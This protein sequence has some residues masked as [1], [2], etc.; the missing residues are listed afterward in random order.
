[1]DEWRAQLHQRVA[2][3]YPET[4][5]EKPEAEREGA[6]PNSVLEVLEEF[7]KDAQAAAAGAGRKVTSLAYEKNATPADGARSAESC[8]EDLR[9]HSISLG[10]SSAALTDPASDKAN[11]FGSPNSD[12]DAKPK[13]AA[14]GDLTVKTDVKMENQ[15]NSAYPS[16]I[17]PFVIPK[18]VS[19]Q[20]H[21]SSWFTSFCSCLFWNCTQ[22][23]LE[24]KHMYTLGTWVLVDFDHVFV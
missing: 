21:V 8:L 11:G 2:D 7:E 16:R 3:E 9:P 18:M 22:N 17:L 23:T 13:D 19:G 5:P 1:V 6:I 10:S 14:T 24:L 15:W 12:V 20:P 4:E